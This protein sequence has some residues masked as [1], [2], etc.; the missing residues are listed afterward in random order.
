MSDHATESDRHLDLVTMGRRWVLDVSALDGAAAEQMAARWVRCRDLAATDTLLFDDEPVTITVA[1]TAAPY[2]LSRELTRAGLERLTGRVLLLHAAALADEGGRTLVLVAPS[3]GG[4]STATRVL[5]QE[6][7]YVSDE[8]VVLL[9]DH[10][11]APHPKPPSLVADPAR[12]GRKDEPS[13]DDLGL[14][15]TPSAPYLG[16]LLTLAREPD[17]AEPSIEPVG[18]IDQVLAVLPETSSTWLLPD[19][20]D[21]L[22]RAA[23]AG[24][25]P[26]RLRYSEIDACRDLVRDH[27]AAKG[28]PAPVWEHLPPAEG[29]HLEGAGREGRRREGAADSGADSDEDVAAP[30][31]AADDVLARGPWSDAI[32]ADGEVL[33]LAGERPLRLAGPGGVLWR[34]A[35]TGRSLAELVEAVI[36]ELGPHPD[37]G[38]LVREAAADLLLHGALVRSL[39]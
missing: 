34:V 23:T 15:A 10:R 13:P 35:G 3:G 6:L 8:S 22:A 37:A 38:S 19:G 33:V 24:G 2:D 36:D 25:A 32:A 4:K 31:L 5:G 1:A 20:L 27:L 18:L 12:P 29:Q 26:A 28:A 11:I 30:A 21:R 39:R 7:G 14:G 16:R 17:V 9:E